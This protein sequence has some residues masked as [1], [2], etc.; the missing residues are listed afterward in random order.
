M[1]IFDI[2][3]IIVAI[4][5]VFAYINLKFIR[6]PTTIGVLLISLI[7]SIVLIALGDIGLPIRNKA[8]EIIGSLDFKVTLLRG[9]LS[10]LLFA[11]AIQLNLSELMKVKFTIA[12]LSIIGTLL[13]TFIVGTIMYYIFIFFGINMNYLY[14][15]LFG[16]IISPTDP[17]AVLAM[18][19][20]TKAPMSLQMEIA[21]E[22]L[23]N[24]GIGVVLFISLIELIAEGNTEGFPIMS[25]IWFFV[26]EV[27]GGILFGFI[28]GFIAKQFFHTFYDFI[29]EVLLT[30]ALVMGGYAL[31]IYL[32]VSGPIA[33][34]VAGLVLSIKQEGAQYNQLERFWELIEK[35]LNLSLFV[36]MGL[37]IL[38]FSIEGRF[39]IEGLIAIPVV[40]L[41]RVVSV[42][43]PNRTMNLWEKV[44][45]KAIKILSWGGLK[46]GLAIAMA[47][48]IP[49]EIVPPT[50]RQMIICVT[51]IVVVFSVV[52]QGITFR[53]LKFDNIE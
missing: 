13:S 29:V 32:N 20:D 23:F 51:Y 47:L 33:M 14:C 40:L 48:A 7:A 24:D 49:Q 19:Q 34:V 38:M 17:V 22:S 53:H 36:L 41:A 2:L 16:S 28:L 39:I 9:M 11:G 31:A 1:N 44:S 18:L 5:A 50:V 46:G 45:N 42:W 25:T 8:Q 3:G 6:L 26:Q 10:F 35:L 27:A 15:L 37:E 52:V 43:L 12:I 30:L 21:G 4:V